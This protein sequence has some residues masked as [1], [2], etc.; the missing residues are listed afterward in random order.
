MG[1]W[2]ERSIPWVVVYFFSKKILALNTIVLDNFF[3]PMELLCTFHL[4]NRWDLYGKM[5]LITEGNTRIAEMVF[6]LQEGI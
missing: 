2:G 6:K 5:D 3:V 4:E 1:K